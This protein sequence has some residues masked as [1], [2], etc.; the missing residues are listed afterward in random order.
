M[1]THIT[2]LVAGS[3]VIIS[4][5]FTQISR[6]THIPSV[7]MLMVLGFALKF[8][9]PIN[10][11][12]LMPALELLGTLGVILIVLEAALDLH[13]EKDKLGL[14]SK[15]ALMALMLLIATAG[16]IAAALKF[17]LGLSV[18]TS[19]FYA[20]P[21][22]VLSSAII[23]PSVNGLKEYSKEFLIFESA[24]SD[25]LG[26]ILFYSIVDYHHADPG[27]NIG[28]ELII[29]TLLTIGL[30]FIISYAL[31]LIFQYGR[32]HATLFVLIASLLVL[33]SM[34]KLLHLSSLII[35]LVFGLVL[36][37]RQ[38]FFQ[39]RLRKYLNE[40]DISTVLKEFKFI[41]LETAFVVR[42][43]F[44]VAFG[45]S[46][47]PGQL[48]NWTVLLITLIVLVAIY[49]TRFIGLRIV[50]F[51][52][53]EPEIYVAP[54]GL[55]TILLFYA[56]PEDIATDA[57]PPGI[58]LLTV[59]ITNFIMTYGLIKERKLLRTELRKEKI[60][61]ATHAEKNAS[62]QA[63]KPVETSVGSGPTVLGTD[64]E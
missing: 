30:S 38:I 23:I 49:L 15:A 44:F 4:F 8:I 64:G 56:I 11:T 5:I 34:G 48:M 52:R 59:L 58:L 47:V 29:M 32:G 19:L 3:I 39:G 16:L 24:L 22:A 21:L 14:M 42:T 7:L 26:I 43:F 37:N 63:S 1:D 54:R 46:I 60:N 28:T 53:V 12:A 2:I 31:I 50:H 13:L 51:Q 6:R 41:T 10:D 35:I 33:Y 9:L 45:L 57:F 20:V 62:E 61:Y 55:I 27:A 40:E 36:N 18:L 17:I 25:I